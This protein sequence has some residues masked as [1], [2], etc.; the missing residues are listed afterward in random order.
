MST[1]PGIAFVPELKP[2]ILSN[3]HLCEQ[4][5]LRSY[6]KVRTHHLPNIEAKM[7]AV[8]C[9]EKKIK[10]IPLF[11]GNLKLQPLCDLQQLSMGSLHLLYIVERCECR[12]SFKESFSKCT[13]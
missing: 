12:S 6:L 2:K 11:A 5:Q 7:N 3:V 8:N 1:K 4:D 9:P 10:C 13:F